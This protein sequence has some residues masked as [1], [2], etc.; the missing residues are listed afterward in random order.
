M[1]I[2]SFRKDA[3]PCLGQVG[4]PQIKQGNDALALVLLYFLAIIVL[5]AIF[6]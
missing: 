3:L 4:V 6:F 2:F 5:Y 1:M